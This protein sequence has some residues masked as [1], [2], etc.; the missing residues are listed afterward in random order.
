MI[1]SEDLHSMKD[2]ELLKLY[3]E[4]MGELRRREVI[5]TS[6]NPV[7]DYA[8]KIVVDRLKLKRASKEA[9]GYDATDQ[10]KKKYQI[11]GR[12]ITNYNKSRQLSVIRNL[13]NDLFDYIVAVIFDEVFNVLEMWKIPRSV[14]ERYSK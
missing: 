9:K 8:E 12:R 5:R 11:K 14:V 1:T 4:L 2:P 10:E 13:R 7:A 3:A 6:N